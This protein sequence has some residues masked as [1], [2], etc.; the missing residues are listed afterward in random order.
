V[1]E[2]G[3]LAVLHVSDS[4]NLDEACPLVESAYEIDP[5]GADH[6]PPPLIVERIGSADDA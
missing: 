4:S 1:E 2:N 6:R 3:T 5:T